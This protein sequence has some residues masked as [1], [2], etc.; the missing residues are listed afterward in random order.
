VRSRALAGFLCAAEHDGM[1]KNR[2]GHV[3]AFHWPATLK[4]L[5]FRSASCPAAVKLVGVAIEIVDCSRLPV[6]S[7]SQDAACCEGRSVEE[8]RG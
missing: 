7:L 2:L 1:S 4:C 8:H 5:A 3:E 6:L